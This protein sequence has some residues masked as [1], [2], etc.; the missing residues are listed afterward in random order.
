MEDR[1][2]AGKCVIAQAKKDK[3]RE[4]PVNK[5]A[6]N[7]RDRHSNTTHKC[8]RTVRMK[9]RL[10]IVGRTGG[11]QNRQH[12]TKVGEKMWVRIYIQ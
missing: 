11:M 5:H 1:R 9:N 8:K 6:S 10:R 2:E 3:N 7:K 12:I 4:K